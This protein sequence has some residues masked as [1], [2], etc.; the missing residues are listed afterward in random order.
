MIR[1]F[2]AFAASATPYPTTSIAM[3]YEE[4]KAPPNVIIIVMAG[5]DWA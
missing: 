2:F 5:L 3:Q 4:N 1:A